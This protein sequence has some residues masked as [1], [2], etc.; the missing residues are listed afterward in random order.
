MK[1]FSEQFNR[2]KGEKGV[3]SNFQAKTSR[4]HVQEETQKEG[5]LEEVVIYNAVNRLKPS[6]GSQ[7]ILDHYLKAHHISWAE[8]LFL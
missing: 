3:F 7:M 2:L 5:L 6:D 4:H 1:A 8:I